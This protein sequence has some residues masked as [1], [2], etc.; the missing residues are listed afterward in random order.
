[1]VLRTIEGQLFQKKNKTLVELSQ[2]QLLD[3]S[4]EFGNNGCNG[5]EDYNA[6]NYLMEY[7]L[8]TSSSYGFYRDVADFCHHE[9]KNLRYF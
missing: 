2:Q 7:G 8:E 9:K 1:M 5:G 4:W 3:C 6:Y